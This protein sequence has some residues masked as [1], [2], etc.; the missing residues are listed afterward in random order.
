MTDTLAQQVGRKIKTLRESKGLTQAQLASLSLKSVETISNFERGK[1]VPGLVALET[2]AEKL[3]CSPSAFFDDI[4]I[5]NED[6]KHSAAA[7]KVLNAI[8]LLDENDIEILAGLVEVL[9]KNKK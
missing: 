9:E 3:G 1:V 7:Q 5:K 4:T 8:E 6:K 2:L